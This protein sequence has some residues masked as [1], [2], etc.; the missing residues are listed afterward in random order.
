MRSS[1]V[2]CWSRRRGSSQWNCAL[3]AMC[4]LRKRGKGKKR[5]IGRS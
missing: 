5:G 2:S 4:C 3:A 1:S